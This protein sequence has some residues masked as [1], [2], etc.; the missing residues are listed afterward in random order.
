MCSV[1]DAANALSQTL[2]GTHAYF[3]HE[4]GLPLLV[5][6]VGTKPEFTPAKYRFKRLDEEDWTPWYE[7]ADLASSLGL[8]GTDA[9]F[10]YVRPIVQAYLESGPR[11]PVIRM[12]QDENKAQEKSVFRKRSW[13][14]TLAASRRKNSALRKKRLSRMAK[15][16]HGWTLRGRTFRFGSWS[17]R[18]RWSSLLLRRGPGAE[19]TWVDA[20]GP[21]R[22]TA[23]LKDALRLIRAYDSMLT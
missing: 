18:V 11:E 2:R 6:A 15:S 5:E 10:Q 22:F 19:S 20:A 8:L 16:L 1:C 17:L 7:T 21:V 9:S 13:K 12:I 14:Q 23:R 3:T 4:R